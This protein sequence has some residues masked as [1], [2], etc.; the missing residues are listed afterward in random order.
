M[1]KKDLIIINAHT[2]DFEREELMRSF[3]SQIDKTNYDLMVVSH[4]KI[5]DDVL[6]KVEYFIFDKENELLTDLNSK[7]PLFFQN[8][9]FL[10]YTTEARDYNHSIAAYKLFYVGINNAKVLGYKKAHIVEYDSAVKNMNLFDDN[11]KLLEDYS[12]VWYKRPNNQTPISISFPMSFN[13]DNLKKEWFEWDRKNI[14]NC[15]AKTIEDWQLQQIQNQK[16]TYSKE[17][18]IEI[19]EDKKSSLFDDSL[20]INLYQSHGKEQWVC[21]IIDDSNELSMFIN[22]QFEDLLYYEVIINGTL[23]KSKKTPPLCWSTLYLGNWDKVDT[24]SIIIDNKKLKKYDFRQIDKKNYKS[25]NY[26][27]TKQNPEHIMGPTAQ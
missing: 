4:T 23:L 13:I 25:L 2:P 14:L 9:N 22:N 17:D 15:G 26:L 19:Y 12:V 7:F 11:S 8:S 27:K 6:N 1:E 3:I 18:K 24:L 20:V 10:V 5:P 16:D 21:P